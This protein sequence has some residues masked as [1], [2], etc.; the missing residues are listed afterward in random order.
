MTS[1]LK[2]IKQVN[3]DYKLLDA[4]D[5]KRFWTDGILNNASV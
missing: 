3:A 1:P 4:R 5:K 2:K